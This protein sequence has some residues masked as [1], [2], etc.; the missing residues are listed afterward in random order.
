[1]KRIF[2]SG[3]AVLI[4]VAVVIGITTVKE[5][6]S[7]L[8]AFASSQS[9]DNVDKA[10]GVNGNIEVRS[11]FAPEIFQQ[12]NSDRAA[13]GLQPYVW[14]STLAR[15]ANQHNVTMILTG[16]GLAHQCPNEPAPC[17]RVLNEGITW[18]T[19][20]ENIGSTSTGSNIL[21]AIIQNIEGNMLAEVPPNDGHRKN[22]LSTSFHQIGVGVLIDNQ[23]DCSGH[24]RLHELIMPTCMCAV[25][26]RKS[27]GHGMLREEGRHSIARSSIHLT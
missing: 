7:H 16:C 12:I 8:S 4:I 11:Q 17:D 6:S 1:M 3:L 23:G 20:G 25:S 2:G 13:Q 26:R 18:Q 21:T 14:N 19:C 15:G 5:T 24:R 22:L 27:Y 10:G 9:Q